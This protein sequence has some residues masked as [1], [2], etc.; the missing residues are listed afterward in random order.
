MIVATKM[1]KI[2]KP[3]FFT[4]TPEQFVRE[5]VRS[6]GHVEETAGCFSHQLQV[7]F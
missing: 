2:R 1:S 6:I 7:F 5:A 4:P 3:S